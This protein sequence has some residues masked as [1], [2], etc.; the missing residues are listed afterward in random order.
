MLGNLKRLASQM[1]T[2]TYGPS[3]I[4]R[5]RVQQAR[6]DGDLKGGT[7][8]AESLPPSQGGSGTFLLQNSVTPGVKDGYRRAVVVFLMF[9]QSLNLDLSSTALIDSAFCKFFDEAWSEGLGPSTGDLTIC[10]WVDSYPVYKAGDFPCGWRAVRAWRRL[11][12][13]RG[14]HPLPWIVCSAVAVY[15]AHHHGPDFAVAI[16]LMFDAYL[17]PYEVM[18][19]RWRDLLAPVL[20]HGSWM[21]VVCPLASGRPSKT[22]VFDDGVA[23]DSAQ[24]PQIQI[25]LQWFRTTYGSD[26]HQK[27]FR[28]KYEQLSAAFTQ[29]CEWLRLDEF[30]F[31]CYSC[32]HGGPSEDR[33]GDFRSHETVMRRGRWMAQSSLRRYEQPNRLQAVL[34]AL[35]EPLLQH[36][37]ACAVHLPALI[38]SP[39]ALVRPQA[40]AVEAPPAATLPGDGS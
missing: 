8:E 32:R 12:P 17:R 34:T 38:R 37:V 5:A 28:F 36:C 31:S 39:Q 27:I 7:C 1:V 9:C 30:E 29:A 23:F 22:K 13:P 3:H 14:R 35:P 26:P 40:T 10:A 21:L 16:L 2:R 25:V 20:N 6:A 11:R 19:A 15:L 24:R 33:A 18:N 4:H